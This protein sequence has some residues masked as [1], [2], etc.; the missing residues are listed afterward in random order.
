MPEATGLVRSTGANTYRDLLMWFY[1]DLWAANEDM[2][3]VN[4][5]QK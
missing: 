5:D 4:L 2:I 3:V 1:K